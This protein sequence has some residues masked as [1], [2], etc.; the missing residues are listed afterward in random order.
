MARI[1]RIGSRAALVCIVLVAAG[2][3]APAI[4]DQP[5]PLE[6]RVDGMTRQAVAGLDARRRHP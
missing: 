1:G 3:R 2:W 5:P 4:A 6:L